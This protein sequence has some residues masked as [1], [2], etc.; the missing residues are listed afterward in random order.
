MNKIKAIVAAAMFVMAGAAQ[1]ALISRGGGMVYD[2]TLDVTWLAD[3]NYAFTS[4]YAAKGS[5]A[6]PNPD[7]YSIW[8]NGRMGWSAAMQWAE[9]LVYGGFS[10]WRLPTLNTSSDITCSGVYDPGGG[11][12]LQYWGVNCSGGE[13]SHLFVIDLGNGAWSSVLEQGGDTAEQ[14]SNFALFSNIKS[15]QYWSSAEYAPGPY[16]AWAFYTSGGFQEPDAKYAG[17]YAIAVRSGDVGATVPEPQTLA[18]VL[19]VGGAVLVQRRIF[20]LN[21]KDRFTTARG[22]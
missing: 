16:D 5:V 1:S 19:L 13:L 12:G 10:D 14:I 3:M 7:E 20:T 2:T 22:G 8:P 11:L 21:R 15:Y 6:Y 9:S 4:G 18:L 17:L